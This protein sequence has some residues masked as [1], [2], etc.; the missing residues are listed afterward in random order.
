R[1][2]GA[3]LG[4]ELPS[5]VDRYDLDRRHLDVP[6]EELIGWVSEGVLLWGRQQKAGVP[7]IAVACEQLI[8]ADKKLRGQPGYSDAEWWREQVRGASAAAP[9]RPSR[10]REAPAGK[11]P[12]AQFAGRPRPAEQPV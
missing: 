3:G 1:L 12:Q 8:A 10:T 6:D 11:V 7:T 4:Q 9:G 2:T 5:L